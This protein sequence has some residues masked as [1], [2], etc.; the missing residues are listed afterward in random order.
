MVKAESDDIIRKQ[1]KAKSPELSNEDITSLI[2]RIRQDESKGNILVEV[3]NESF[4]DFLQGNFSLSPLIAR[5]NSNSEIIGLEK[6]ISADVSEEDLTNFMAKNQLMLERKQK[7]NDIQPGD[8]V[9]LSINNGMNTITLV[10][11]KIVPYYSTQ[12]KIMFKEN[13]A[14]IKDLIPTKSFSI[15][16]VIKPSGLTV[17]PEVSPEAEKNAKDNVEKM[18]D[19]TSE[20]DRLKKLLEE[21]FNEDDLFNGAEDPDN[22][23]I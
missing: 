9:E 14:K 22:C 13:S 19:F 15:V 23:N 3:T 5:E 21:D 18:D 7:F 6:L 11:D 4:L 10:V 17:K 8:L 12:T 1:L 20:T 2:S 16:D